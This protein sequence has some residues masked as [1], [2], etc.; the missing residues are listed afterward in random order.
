MARYTE[1]EANIGLKAGAD[2]RQREK[3]SKIK[4]YI[5]LFAE[6]RKTIEGL[7]G[8]YEAKKPIEFIRA[9]EV[10]KKKKIEIAKRIV[11]ALSKIHKAITEFQGFSEKSFPFPNKPKGYGTN[12]IE[13]IKDIKN[14]EMYM[15]Y[16]ELIV[17]R[18]ATSLP[19]FL[20]RLG[21]RGSFFKEFDNNSP[22]TIL[23]YCKDAVE[24]LKDI[25]NL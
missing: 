9:R 18:K 5:A 22:Y 13:V 14:L 16:W 1:L 12:M 2:I 19:G 17:A 25:L 8:A 6:N 21:G 23:I 20:N 10:D 3:V 11:S 15:I 4:K 24:R 7:L